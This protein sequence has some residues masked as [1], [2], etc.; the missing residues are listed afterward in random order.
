MNPPIK[1]AADREALIEAV[2]DGTVDMIATDHAPHSAE[3]K[4]KGFAG[5]AYGIVGL[6]TAFP[7]LYT[8]LVRTGILPLEKLIELLSDAPNKRFKIGERAASA[9]GSFSFTV[10]DLETPY[11]V[12]PDS[13]LS[14]GH[15]T[16]FAG[17]EVYGRCMMTVY[18]GKTVFLRSDK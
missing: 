11:R 17:W 8:K 5:S 14:M 16:P 7:V 1:S 15:S 2:L 18:Q 3:E 9:D 6:E 4:S 10:W 13:F 12:D